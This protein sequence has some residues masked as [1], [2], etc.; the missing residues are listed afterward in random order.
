MGGRTTACFRLLPVG[1]PIGFAGLDRAAAFH[2]C[3]GSWL[4]FLLDAVN[5]LSFFVAIMSIHSFS[6]DFFSCSVLAVS[7]LSVSAR[8]LQMSISS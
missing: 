5:F 2:L 6:S 3:Q 8:V 7:T 4:F 1:F